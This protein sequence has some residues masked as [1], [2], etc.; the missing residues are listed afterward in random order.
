M[1]NNN[2]TL[3]RIRKLTVAGGFLDGL[4]VEFTDG[5]ICLIGPRGTGKSTVLEM[6]RYALDALPGKP[7]DP[8][9]KRA[10]SL[11]KSNL[12]EGRIELL[13]ETKDGLP[14]TI[15]RIFDDEPDV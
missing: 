2:P 8:L 5:L 3:N 10:E 12:G 1:K 14:Y 6:M 9:R 11:I 4:E 7:G 15:T 13:V